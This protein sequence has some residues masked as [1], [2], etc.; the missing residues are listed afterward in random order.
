MGD[1]P[2]EVLGEWRSAE[3]RLY[4]VVMLRPDLYERSVELVRRV[5]DELAS[6]TGLD[7]L[8][9]A[10]PAATDT[11]YRV[12]ALALLPLGDLDVSLVAGAA[13]SVRY[14]ELAAKAARQERSQRV[15]AA[16]EAGETWVEV[17]RQGI[18]ETAAFLPYF[19][20]EMHVPSGRALRCIL[21]ADPETGRPH[22]ALETLRL[23]PGT[24][25]VVEGPEATREF[26][27]RADWEAALEAGRQAIESGG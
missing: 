8:V 18:E 14:R 13:F 9:A 17:E 20:L 2:R 1:V 15:R 10:W 5:A 26:E 6:C 7:A 21:E 22:F 24:G 25:E 11:V 12:S 23:D 4:P 19:R 3:D 16:A 27:T